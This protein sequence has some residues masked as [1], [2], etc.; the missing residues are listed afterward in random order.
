LVEVLKVLNITDKQS[1]AIRQNGSCQAVMIIPN[2]KR[3]WTVFVERQLLFYQ[4]R[5]QLIT[6][7]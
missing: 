2:W 7:R 1:M 5:V 4:W 3:L 6:K